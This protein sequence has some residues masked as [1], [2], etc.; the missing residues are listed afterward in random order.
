MLLSSWE[1]HREM[2]MQVSVALLSFF[3]IRPLSSDQLC[4]HK[5]QLLRLL[6][7]YPVHHTA[8]ERLNEV[9]RR[10][11]TTSPLCRCRQHVACVTSSPHGSTTRPLVVDS[12]T[13]SHCAWTSSMSCLLG[14]HALCRD[15]ILQLD[16]P[17]H[18]TR[19]LVT[20]CSADNAFRCRSKLMRL[21]GV[22]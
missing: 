12:R 4:A 22:M 13:T 11:P 17:W 18:S 16:E 2:T 20:T 1:R 7:W 3:C 5:F 15:F 9:W 8:G 19:E 6:S 21:N 14:I 10:Q